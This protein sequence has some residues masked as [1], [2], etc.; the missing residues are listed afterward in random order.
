[1]IAPA[2]SLLCILRLLTLL[3]LLTGATARADPARGVR[4]IGG[5]P[6][7]VR[8]GVL[9]VPL[10]ADRDGDRWPRKLRLAL[11]QHRRIEGVVAWIFPVPLSATPG[12][13]DDPRGL[14]VRRIERSDDTTVA[15]SGTPYLL[16]RLP[17]NGRGPLRLG[18]Q[19]LRVRWLDAPPRRRPP[20]DRMRFV[21]RPDRPDSDSPLEYWRWVVLSERLGMGPPSTEAYG[22]VGALVAEHYADL[23]R[24]GLARLAAASPGVA[25]R[26]RDLLTRTCLDQHQ[27]FAAWVAEPAR[28]SRLLAVLLDL[29]RSASAL[30]EDASAWVDDQD[31]LLVMAEVGAQGVTVAVANPTDEPIVV[32]FSWGDGVAIPVAAQIAPGLLRRVTLERPPADRRNATGGES[33]E[34]PQRLLVEAAGRQRQLAFPG[35]AIPVKP[36]GVFFPPLGPPLTLVELQTLRPHPMNPD[37]ATFA[38]VRRLND[39]WEVF[40]ECRRPGPPAPPG[41]LSQRAHFADARGIEAVAVLLGP[42]A[43]AGGPAVA[44]VVPEE[45]S[46]R[47]FRGRD[48]GS[49]AVHRRSYADRWYC[50]VVVPEGWLATEEGG[51]T[52]I[53]FLRTHGDG[54]GVET[55]PFRTLPWRLDPGRAVLDTTNWDDDEEVRS[56]ESGVRSQGSADS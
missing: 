37:R 24:V 54:P 56:Q 3:I 9:M 8:G 55:G 44:L 18:S 14:S 13:T 20:Q 48:D 27:P 41:D 50:R 7:A 22:E 16:A 51:S 12:W 45:G 11:S 26:C 38:N 23:W 49:L 34:P 28:T 17:P 1:M 30:A 15:A 36:P 35:G 47:L 39:R 29:E 19:S 10:V 21:E 25:K 31:L 33:L 2:G 6:I 42:E 46:P 52:L 40:F 5:E 4:A 43:A 53:G 32:K